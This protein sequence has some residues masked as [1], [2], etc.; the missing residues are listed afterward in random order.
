M[1]AVTGLLISGWCLRL[2][3]PGRALLGRGR[4]EQA[5]ITRPN[6]DRCHGT[7]ERFGLSQICGRRCPAQVEGQGMCADTITHDVTGAPMVKRGGG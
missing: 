7:L 6:G 2:G 5:E 4:F 1:L 3:S